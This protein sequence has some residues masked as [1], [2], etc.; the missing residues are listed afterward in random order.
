MNSSW[1]NNSF[2]NIYL[3]FSIHSTFLHKSFSYLSYFDKFPCFYEFFYSTEHSHFKTLKRGTLYFTFT[4]QIQ[5]RKQRLSESLVKKMFFRSFFS[6]LAI[7]NGYNMHQIQLS[8][9]FFFHNLIFGWRRSV[10]FLFKI[11]VGFTIPLPNREYFF[12]EEGVPVA[13]WQTW[14]TTTS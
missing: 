13:L 3:K 1:K 4:L 5:P 7:N 8:I 11:S 2:F 10:F 12:L 9:V 14:W 6:I